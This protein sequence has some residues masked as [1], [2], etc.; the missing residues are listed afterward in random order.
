MAQEPKDEESGFFNRWSQRK[1]QA[2]REDA[3]RDPADPAP[4]AAAP[5]PESTPHD[6]PELSEEELAALPAIDDLTPESDI[7]AFMRAGVPKSLRNAALRK[8]WLITPA[9]RNHVDPAVD[10]AW[11]WNTP[12]GVPGDGIAPSPEKAAQML[13]DLL[14][15]RD[16]PTKDA[17][18]SAL[19][20]ASP[21]DANEADCEEAASGPS[22][23]DTPPDPVR[24]PGLQQKVTPKESSPPKQKVAEIQPAPR[25]HGGALPE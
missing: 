5:E 1:Q 8:M 21:V 11:D 25:R 7:R 23:E 16:P 6:V 13:R 22:R 20:H 12:G 18:D 14:K 15:P 4:E 19:D 24:L 10:Y 2:I 9:I 3:P 17:E